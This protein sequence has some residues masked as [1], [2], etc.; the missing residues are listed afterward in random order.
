MIKNNYKTGLVSVSFRKESPENIFKAMKKA[1]LSY[2]E[3]G[4]DIHAPYND[5][6]NLKKLA[7]LQEE[8]G[9]QCSSYGTYFR[10]GIT[11]IEELQGYIDA[12]RILKT[13]ILRLWCYDKN[14]ADMTDEERETLVIQCRKAAQIAEENNVTLC[15]ECH[16]NTFTESP[17]DAVLLMDEINSTHFRMYWQP[18]QWQPSDENVLNAKIIAPYAMHL[19]VFNWKNDKKLPLAGA[20][21]EWQDYLAQF[22]E[23]HTLLLEFMPDDTLEELETEADS[24]RKIINKERYEND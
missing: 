3:W 18:F 22:S 15:L 13:N 4:S 19:H 14:S 10:L 21:K 17:L 20:I 24:L 5:R 23:E 11:P 8:Y 6:E 12:A 2:I 9:I 7:E 1:N 16:M